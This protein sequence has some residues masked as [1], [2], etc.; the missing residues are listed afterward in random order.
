MTWP[1]FPSA[2]AR[3]RSFPSP[4]P[5]A[6]HAERA[7]PRGTVQSRSALPCHTHPSLSPSR[8]HTHTCARAHTRT[9]VR[10]IFGRARPCT[11]SR[12]C[13]N[14]TAAPHRPAAGACLRTTPTSPIPCAQGHALAAAG[15]PPMPKHLHARMPAHAVVPSSHVSRLRR[16]PC[17]QHPGIRR[18]PPLCHPLT[19]T[20][21]APC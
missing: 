1:P 21:T 5:A 15:S 8:T 12:Q 4:V 10:C 18:A 7:L 14:V 9:M 2:D 6:D 13:T 17:P 20:T 3:R 11:C 19:T 16:R